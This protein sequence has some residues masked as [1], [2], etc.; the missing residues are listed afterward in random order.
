[1]DR[2]GLD[3]SP[4]IPH[5]G[6]MCLLDSIESWAEDHIVCRAT[7]HRRPDNPLR[8]DSGLRALCSIE[9]AAQAIAAHAALLREPSGRSL[10][11]GVLASARDVTVMLSH[12]DD[13]LG[14]LTIRATLLLTHEEGSIYDVM[15]T[16]D[17]RTVMTGR[18][19]V[20]MSADHPHMV[21]PAS[22]EGVA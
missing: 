15:M 8:D 16:G 17:G 20:M 6:A 7:S 13:L 14:P 11:S 19:S 5:R 18:L 3:I 4:L 21:Q 12:L 2:S 22:P 9:Y 1:M 10:V